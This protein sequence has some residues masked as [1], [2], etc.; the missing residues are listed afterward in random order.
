MRI[1]S[2]AG[3]TPI[4][5][6]SRPS[7]GVTLTQGSSHILL[8]SPDEIESVFGAIATLLTTGEAAPPC[9]NAT[10]HLRK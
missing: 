8:G 4:W 7:G 5:I 10:N 2:T 6:S 3:G 9:E 1:N